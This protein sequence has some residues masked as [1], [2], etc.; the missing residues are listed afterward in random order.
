MARTV[1]WSTSYV[2]LEPDKSVKCYSTMLHEHLPHFI[3]DSK[4]SA[5]SFCSVDKTPSYMSDYISLENKLA[6]MTTNTLK[7]WTFWEHSI[8]NTLIM[9]EFLLGN[10]WKNQGNY[11]I[12]FLLSGLLGR[13]MF[14]LMNLLSYLFVYHVFPDI[15]NF[16]ILSWTGC[17]SV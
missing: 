13:A 9:T 15:M 1:M 11:K 8:G 5:V 7:T 14:Q 6:S 4:T 10:E 2:M 3:I 12:W 17:I 16:N